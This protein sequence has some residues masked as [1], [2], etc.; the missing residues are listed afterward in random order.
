MGEFWKNNGGDIIG[1]GLGLIGMGIG[2]AGA[3]AQQERQQEYTKE[4]MALNYGY[5]E[6]AANNA[7]DR[8]M[9]L[10]QTN[11]ELYNSPQALRKAYE[12]AGLSVGLMYNQGGVGG[13]GAGT[14]AP[15]GAG[16][17]GASAPQAQNL[18]LAALQGAQLGLIN[19]QTKKTE[20]EANAIGDEN[21]RENEKQPLVIEGLNLG[22]ASKEIENGIAR[23]NKQIKELDLKYLT[24]TY[25][26]KVQLFETEVAIANETLRSAIVKADIDEATKQNLIDQCANNTALSAVKVLQANKNLQLT[27]AQI[28]NI[29]QSTKTQFQQMWLFHEQWN[30]TSKQNDYYDA[31]FAAKIDGIYGNLAAEF[32]KC[33]ILD[34]EAE[35]AVTKANAAMKEAE[36]AAQNAE[37]N[38]KRQKHD[39]AYDWAEYGRKWVNMFVEAYSSNNRSEAGKEKAKAFITMATALAKALPK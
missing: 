21:K 31:E 3:K 34:K 30:F 6:Q 5:N 8:Q 37:T 13:S 7:M 24:A 39:A 15:Q 38:A 32:I 11:W 18:G 1:S 28:E 23:Y 16:A 26:E 35:A 12:D 14:S 25:D 10:N 19:A 36:A 22:N 20:A 33:G 17:A 4:N 27:D 9:A 2:M 29:K